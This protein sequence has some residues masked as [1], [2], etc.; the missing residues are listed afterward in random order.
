MFVP[1]WIIPM[2]DSRRQR[3]QQMG[4]WDDALLL[5]DD[6][7]EETEEEEE[8]FEDMLLRGCSG[9]VV[10]RCTGWAA[11]VCSCSRREASPE[12]DINFEGEVR[13]ASSGLLGSENVCEEYSESG[14]ISGV[15]VLKC[16]EDAANLRGTTMLK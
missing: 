12:F 7:E 15:S 10:G 9:S 14:V 5:R 11:A 16:V 3:Q 2:R 1:N 4:A 6:D 8:L 13:M